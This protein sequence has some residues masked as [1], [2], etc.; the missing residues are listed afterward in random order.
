MYPYKPSHCS[1]LVNWT[2]DVARHHD[3]FPY[4]AEASFTLPIGAKE[5]AFVAEGVQQYGHFELSQTADAGS[6]D[7]IVDVHVSYDQA[8]ALSD[9]TV[10]R[11][12]PAEDNWG[13]G[14]FVCARYCIIALSAHCLC[15]LHV[16]AS[17]DSSAAYA[18]RAQIPRPRPPSCCR[19]GQPAQDREPRHCSTAVHASYRGHQRDR[20][21]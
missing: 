11:L 20:L 12:H 17:L 9:A 15:A 5:L 19:L 4:H 8:E 10:C 6:D 2:T 18:A 16:D 3:D 13:L 7:A 14:I 1:E 21:L